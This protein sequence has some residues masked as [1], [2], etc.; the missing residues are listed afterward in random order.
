MFG[1]FLG[2]MLVGIVITFVLVVRFIDKFF[3]FE[4]V[5]I[6]YHDDGKD[7]QK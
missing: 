3:D 1:M 5:E 6:L 4:E 7:G 2:G